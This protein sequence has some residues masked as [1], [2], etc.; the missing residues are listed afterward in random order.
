MQNNCNVN[1]THTHHQVRGN[2]LLKTGW[3]SL[4][5]IRAPSRGFRPQKAA[6]PIF[7]NTKFPAEHQAKKSSGSSKQTPLPKKQK[8]SQGSIFSPRMFP[9]LLKFLLKLQIQLCIGEH[10]ENV[11]NLAQK[12]TQL[13]SVLVS[14]T[15]ILSSA[16]PELLSALCPAPNVEK[17]WSTKWKQ[18]SSTH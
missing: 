4:Y 6:W 14:S 13:S 11:L 16:N 1:Q 9:K 5:S 15:Q 3:G 18:A 2:Y 7:W 8:C 12:T 10:Y 17:N